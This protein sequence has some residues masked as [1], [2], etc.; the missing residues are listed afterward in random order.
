[1]TKNDN[2]NEEVEIA[3]G[4]PDFLDVDVVFFCVLLSQRLSRDLFLELEDGRNDADDG[5]S[6]EAAAAEEEDEV[7]SPWKYQL[8]NLDRYCK[9]LVN[10]SRPSKVRTQAI[11]F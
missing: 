4:M 2:S 6:A 10:L 1:M 9:S 8:K 11:Q 5:A 7:A 3:G